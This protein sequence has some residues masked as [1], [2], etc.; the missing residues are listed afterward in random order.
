MVSDAGALA[1]IYNQGIADRV[2]TF[3]T[4]PRSSA[5]IAAWFSG[6][7]LIVVVETVATSNPG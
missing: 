7:N 3:E 6:R 2:A 1:E 4:E 5:Q